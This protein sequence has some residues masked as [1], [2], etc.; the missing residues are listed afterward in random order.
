[1]MRE[2]DSELALLRTKLDD[3]Q[4]ELIRKEVE[5]AV[6]KERMEQQE[7]RMQQELKLLKL[8]A[9]QSEKYHLRQKQKKAN[10]STGSSSNEDGGGK[11][12]EIHIQE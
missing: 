8:A 3:Q 11:T 2:K 5:I 9:F 6:L 10:G 7:L 12:K 4:R 1:M